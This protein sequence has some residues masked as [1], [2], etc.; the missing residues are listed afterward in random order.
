MNCP[1]CKKEMVV[2]GRDDSFDSTK[3]NKKYNRTVYWCETDDVWVS[4][5]IPKD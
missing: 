5:E 4:V 3:D 2:K 1:E